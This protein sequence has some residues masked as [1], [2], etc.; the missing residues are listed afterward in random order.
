MPLCDNG[1]LKVDCVVHLTL[2]NVQWFHSVFSLLCWGQSLSTKAYFSKV[3]VS[4]ETRATAR[5]PSK[6]PGSSIILNGYI[7]DFL[8]P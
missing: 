7:S 5:A 1:L 8:C 6:A 4:A 2:Q 3:E